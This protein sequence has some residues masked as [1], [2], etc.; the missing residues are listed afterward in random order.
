MGRSSSRR[1]SSSLKANHKRRGKD[2][3]DVI[4]IA[5]AI[6]GVLMVATLLLVILQD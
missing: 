5:A 4:A 1:H 6:F 2:D 3:I